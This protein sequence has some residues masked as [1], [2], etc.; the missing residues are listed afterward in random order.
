MNTC[1]CNRVLHHRVNPLDLHR[2]FFELNFKLITI[3]FL[4]NLVCLSIFILIK[5]HVTYTG[6]LRYPTKNDMHIQVIIHMSIDKCY[7]YLIYILKSHYNYL[8]F[9][10]FITYFVLKQYELSFFLVLIQKILKLMTFRVILVIFCV[11]L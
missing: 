10:S 7:A 3:I 9:F 5:V 8:I 1:E 2:K 4:I 6:T 11:E